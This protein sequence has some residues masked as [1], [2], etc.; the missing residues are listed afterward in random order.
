[1]IKCIIIEDEPQARNILKLMLGE[2]FPDIQVLSEFD[3]VSEACKFI[4]TNPVQFVFLDVQLNGELGLDIAKYI[5]MSKY[6][7]DIIFSTAYSDYAIEA[8]AL[9]AIDYLLKP[10]NPD[11]FKE[12]V[13]RVLQK[14]T[15]SK[16]QLEVLQQ[17][18]QS[19]QSDKIILKNND[20]NHVVDVTQILYLKASNSY[21]EFYFND[22]K[23]IV[24]S[25]SIKEYNAL[26]NNPY[27]YKTHR[28]YIIN[29]KF[30]SSYQKS[31]LIITLNNSV[32]ISLSREKKKEFEDLFF[33][34]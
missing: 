2:Y 25:K 31:D 12:A 32:K 29:T 24:V 21:T 20:G 3:K 27:F 11:R 10:I 17:I 19:Q 8:F 33:N 1:M 6:N 15:L 4:T 18:S 22:G 16:E 30:M 9:A 26:L 14:N 34:K 13:N 28:S 5:D 23:R 7:F